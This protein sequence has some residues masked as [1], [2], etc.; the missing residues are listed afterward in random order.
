MNFNKYQNIIQ[1]SKSIWELV[2]RLNFADEFYY[3]MMIQKIYL[4][5]KVY[6]VINIWFCIWFQLNCDANNVFI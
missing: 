2:N 1:I 3:Q 5:M 6:Y 4:L